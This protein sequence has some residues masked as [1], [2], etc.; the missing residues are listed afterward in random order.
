MSSVT[1]ALCGGLG[2]QMF[3]YAM[4][5]AL[6]IRNGVPLILDLYGFEFD[7]FYKR[8]FELNN[9]NIPADL[10]KI[11]SFGRFHVGRLVNNLSKSVG[12]VSYLVR[13]RLLVERTS[14]YD[15]T[16]AALPLS[17]D[18]FVMGY[19]QDERYFSDINAVIK[20]EF[21]LSRGFSEAN[22]LVAATIEATEDAVAVHV[23]RLHHIAKQADVAPKSDAEQKGLAVGINYYTAGL[24]KIATRVRRP[25]YF[26][27]S[28]YPQWARENLAID[29]NVT[30]LENNRG[31]DYEDMALMSLC[32]HHVIANSSFSWWGAWL[33]RAEGQI[34]IAPENAKHLPNIPAYWDC[35]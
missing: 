9:F 14:E 11:K 25:T 20:H 10:S 2:N 16:V 1:V 26:V 28:D 31:Q 12:F 22:R 35:L 33:A 29:G 4:G 32:R 6:S 34:V 21:T 27:F 13:S 5:R 7:K 19:W 18:V 3:Q 24:Q 23:R 15:Q 17:R 30:F 8:S